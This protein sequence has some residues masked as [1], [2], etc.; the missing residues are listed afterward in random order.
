MAQ[1]HPH[2]HH[3]HHDKYAVIRNQR[4]GLVLD[5]SDC[6]VK[7]Q[8]FTGFPAQLWK[9]ED[10]CPG[11]FF[12]VNKGNGKVLDIDGGLKNGSNL[13]TYQKHGGSNQQWHVNSDGTIV[14]AD[15]NLAV[16]ICRENY[17]PGN[18]LIAYRKHGGANQQFTFQYQ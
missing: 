4:S 6:V 2:H 12:I 18:N 8:H 7:I 9:L 1:C 13:L 16:D 15:G 17:T 3:H 11:K 14:S 10:A 5:A